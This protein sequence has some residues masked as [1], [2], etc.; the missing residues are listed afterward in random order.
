MLVPFLEFASMTWV[1]MSADTD[2]RPILAYETQ[3]RYSPDGGW[4]TLAISA[5]HRAAVDANLCPCDSW[6][7]TP[8]EVRIVAI[9]SGRRA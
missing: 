2:N 4:I 7:R 9:R 1:T 5:S 8:T 3:A 6:G